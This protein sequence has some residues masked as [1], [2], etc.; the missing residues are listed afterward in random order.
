MSFYW[1]MLCL[2]WKYCIPVIYPYW[3]GV[4]PCKGVDHRFFIGGGAAKAHIVCFGV[5]MFDEW[6]CWTWHKIFVQQLPEGWS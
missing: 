1:D 4:N 5:V 6:A 2:R 3:G